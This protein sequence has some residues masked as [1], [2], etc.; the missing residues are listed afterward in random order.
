MGRTEL[1]NGQILLGL[2][3]DSLSGWI[4]GEGSLKRRQMAA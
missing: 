4:A 3:I 1:R 2:F